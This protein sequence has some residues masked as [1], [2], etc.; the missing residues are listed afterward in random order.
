MPPYVFDAGLANWLG[1]QLLDT[2]Q[3]VLDP[4]EEARH[5]A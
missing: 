3:A 2:L 4:A 5:A 1:E